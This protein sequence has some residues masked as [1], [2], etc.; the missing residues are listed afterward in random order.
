MKQQINSL[1]YVK[2]VTVEVFKANNWDTLN[3][4]LE[5][6]FVLGE[7][8]SNCLGNITHAHIL[9]NFYLFESQADNAC[10]GICPRFLQL[11]QSQGQEQEGKNLTM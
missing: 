11:G 8:V 4:Q 5:G 10:T 3:I 2:Y 1:E 9:F 7:R 6:N